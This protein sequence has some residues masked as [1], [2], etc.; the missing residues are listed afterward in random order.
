MKYF[1]LLTALFIAFIGRAQVQDDFSDG[2]FSTNPEWLG[3]GADYMIN[4]VFQLQLN[5]TVAGTSYLHTLLLDNDFDAKEWQFWVRQSFAGSGT[6]Y[7]RIYLLTSA[8][9]LSTN[10][11]GVYLQLGEA[12]NN[13]AIRLVQRYNGVNTTICSTADASIANS[14]SARVKVV[15]S[16]SGEWSLYSDFTSGHTF[17]SPFTGTEAAVP[18]GDK[19]GYL[20]VY[21]ASNAN[22]FYLDDVYYGPQIFDVTP[23][24][25]SSNTLVSN[26][27]LRVEFSE[28]VIPTVLDIANWVFT[29][30]LVPQN[31][32]W[33]AGSNTAIEITFS[34]PFTNALLYAFTLE[35]L[36]DLA[37]NVADPLHGSFRYLVSEIAA[38]GDV[39][40]NEFFPDPTPIIGLPEVEFV[41][42]YNRSNKTFNLRG[43]KIGDN[44]TFGT[45]NSD[46][47]MFPGDHVVL[48]ANASV[49]L[50][51]NSVGVTSWPALNNS[52]DD[53]AIVTP[54]GLELER[55][56][57]TL[58]WYHD[59]TKVDGGWTI[60]R[61]N[62]LSEC[63]SISNWR[64]SVDPSG[65]TPA[66]RNSVYDI[67]PDVTPPSLSR[68]AFSQ[69]TLTIYFSEAIV[70][71]E[72]NIN[73]IQISPSLNVVSTIFP[74]V[75]NDRLKMVLA[76]A[77]PNQTYVVTIPSVKD[78]RGNIS[79]QLIDSFKFF[80]AEIAAIGDVIINEFMA[81]PTPVVGL[82]EVEFVEIYNR[83]TKTFNLKGW[84]LGDNATQGTIGEF[85]L[86]PNQH[87]VLTPNN[88][89]ALFEGNVVGVTSFPSLGNN[90]D[91]V[92]IITKEGLELERIT[93]TI[94]WYQDMS[95]KDG[96]WTIERI[97]PLTPCSSMANWRASIDETGG[98]PGYI[99]S[100]Y[101]L[102]PDTTPPTI[103][104]IFV[105]NDTVYVYFSESVQSAGFVP[106]N[107]L[108]TPNANLHS[109]R[110]D[111]TLTSVLKLVYDDIASNVNYTLTL[112]NLTDCAG[113]AT[114]ISIDFG[115]PSQAEVGDV[116][117]NEVL[118]D[119]FTGGND[120]VELYNNSDK[121]ID[122]KGWKF[123]KY[124]SGGIGQ[125]KELSKHYLL[126]PKAYVVVGSDSTYILNHY[127]FAPSGV[128]IQSPLPALNSDSSTLYVMFPS[129]GVDVVMD[130]LSY[131][132]KWHFKLLDN[133]KGKSL[134]RLRFNQPTQDKNN[135]HTAAER[136]GW[137]TPGIV[138]SQYSP[139][140]FS[141]TIS[142][143]SDVIS[144]DNDGF[145]D[146]LHVQYQMETE[147]MIATIIIYDEV[148]R[149]IKK[150]INNELLG[151]EGVIIWDGVRTDGLKAKVGVYV[152]VM[153][154]Y[155]ISG[156]K[157]RAKKAFTVATKL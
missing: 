88:S 13:D 8:T 37:G 134:E 118:F 115:V 132:K 108:L 38:V 126:Q 84:K 123:S 116:V 150:V 113:N 35:N 32:A 54:E 31:I 82:P 85:W 9:D 48:V 81:D 157:F 6:N 44:A 75:M 23:P 105:S 146:L 73:D 83:S 3:T 33:V 111:G 152:L 57:Y 109:I 22:R 16:T 149:E 46:K 19:L 151:R 45:I 60:E 55:F 94:N 27:V 63:S 17:G 96:G 114:D 12:G 106:A 143:A 61:I 117:I 78:C 71:A 29:P 100:V 148:G 122:L 20:N 93:Y 58:S 125:T 66:L 104:E 119:P 72:L 56:T 68:L 47:W 43:W 145:E 95:K 51:N 2:D 49:S 155:S 99:N 102:S 62:P 127:P 129:A 79:G 74:G 65:G 107:I 110:F 86:L 80:I 120:W 135:W 18:V 112:L 147:G 124:I 21:T 101:D 90:G 141:G 130:K 136:M 7:G 15:R 10:P 67:T 142:F 1:F 69:D 59:A 36:E 156:E 52:T 140:D 24:T 14:F 89:V 98:T 87:V 42:I 131:S 25:I 28:P 11:D 53:V 154:A 103:S 5:K 64:A 26:Q 128:Y 137:G 138:N 121:W 144:P 40:I 92:A 77:L 34:T 50:F 153:E 41:E 91:D 139:E 4:P 76:G 133:T 30:T 97:N 70:V 39:I